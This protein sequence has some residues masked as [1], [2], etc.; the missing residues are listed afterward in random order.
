MKIVVTG[1]IA[2]DYIMTYPGEFK[3]MLLADNLDHISVSFLVD[4]MTRHR[5]GIGANIAEA[6]REYPGGR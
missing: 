6:G 3:E 5:G 4:E 2:Y 1:S